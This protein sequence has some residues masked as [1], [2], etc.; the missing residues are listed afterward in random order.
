MDQAQALRNHMLSK[1]KTAK[2]ITVVSGKGGVGKSNFS[3]NWAVALSSKGYRTLLIDMDIGM[4]NVHILLGENPKQSIFH[5]LKGQAAI[6]DIIHK[7]PA[8][9]DFISG[10][11]GLNNLME[12]QSEEMKQMLKGFEKL[13]K[14]YDYIIFDMGAGATAGGI[15]LTIAAD[16]VFVVATSEPTSIMDA[17]SMM[18]FIHLKDPDKTMLLLCNRVRN[19]S[20]GTAV[21]QR[22]KTAMQRFLNKEIYYLGNLPEDQNVRKAVSAQYPF[23][24][25]FPA[26]AGSKKLKSMVEAY[27]D[28]RPGETLKASN[29]FLKRLTSIFYSK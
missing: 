24:L 22:L 1:Q 10:G 13:Q 26:A 15:E 18:K 28:N 14:I 3:L 20:E 9:L 19:D 17:Y 2:V 27:L 16:E 23:I 11:S 5:Y 12:W 21:M 8:D 6:E 29:R 4:G 25:Q 7:G